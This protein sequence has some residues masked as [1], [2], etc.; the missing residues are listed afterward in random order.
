MDQATIPSRKFAELAS[1][2][3]GEVINAAIQFGQYT[4]EDLDAMCNGD[5]FD[6]PRDFSFI[7]AGH[8]G[9]EVAFCIGS[10]WRHADGITERALAKA[11]A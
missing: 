9:L 3:H 2:P 4:C 11:G 6:L 5:G 1:L 7:L 8:F 10:E